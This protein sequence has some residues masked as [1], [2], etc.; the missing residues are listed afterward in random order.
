MNLKNIKVN[1]RYIIKDNDLILY[2]GGSGISFKMQGKSFTVHALFISSPGYFYVI[3][4]RQFNEKTKILISKEAYTH[5]LED[6]KPHLVDIVKANECNDNALRIENLKVDGELLPF[7]HLYKNKV[8]V[9]GDSTV[10]G[11]GIL[12]QSGDAS[13]H[14]CDAVQDFFFGGLYE[15]NMDVDIMSASGY[16][17]AFSIYTCPNNIGIYDFFD[18]VGVHKK[19]EWPVKPCDLLI[20]SVGTNDNSYIQDDLSKKEE[21]INI[22]KQKY[23]ALIEAYLQL[24]PNTKILM[25]GG[26]LKEQT[27]YYLY[28]ETYYYLKAFYKNLTLHMFNGDNSAISNHAYVAAH[29]R[30]KDELKAVIKEIL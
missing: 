7:D 29:E 21:R 30:M 24:N 17:L 12:A 25:V 11:F 14:N 20:I 2:N 23:K 18:K 5:F 6:D 13:I 15:M 28:E 26:T 9:Y 27:V 1:G 16:G 8:V 3:I 10:A 22:F 19:A 4:D